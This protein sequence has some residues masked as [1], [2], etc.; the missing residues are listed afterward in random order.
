MTLS[1]QTYRD[2]SDEMRQ[3]ATNHELLGRDREFELIKKAQAGDRE[4]ADNLV[5]HN[6]R[7]VYFI[8][9][10]Y[11]HKG[12]GGD[13]DFMDLV[14]WGNL[15]MLHAIEKFEPD[16]GHRFSTYS[17]WW[18]RRFIQ[19]FA[20]MRGN[21]LGMS[22]QDA[23][24]ALCV[25]AART[26]LRRRTH[27]EPSCSDIADKLNLSEKIVNHL[28]PSL[29]AISNLE[30]PIRDT[31]G[32]MIGDMLPCEDPLPEDCIDDNLMREKLQMAMSELPEHHQRVLALRYGLGG[33]EISTYADIGKE[34]HVSRT[35][36]QQIEALA[37]L[38]L[39]IALK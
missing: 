34:L 35:R 38:K 4:A 29:Q 37:L 39:K 32:L 1:T 28:T 11:F 25:R 12:A 26:E 7:L 2:I 6:Q 18:I 5:S 10:N 31:D 15:G 36:I 30:E 27:R 20:M 33:E 8:A 21:P 17:V 9:N 13:Q 16:R 14:Q 23:Y 22:Y 24:R 3:Q 19:R